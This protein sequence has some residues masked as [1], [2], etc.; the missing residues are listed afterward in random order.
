MYDNNK[1]ELNL[2]RNKHSEETVQKILDASLKLFLEKGYEQTSILDIVENLGGLTRGAFYHHFKSKAEVLDALGDRMSNENNFFEKIKNDT[3]LNGLQKIQKIIKESNESTERKTF[4]SIVLQV[5][6]LDHPTF[7]SALI[8]DNIYE[9]SPLFQ[10][11]IEEGIADG[12]IPNV[13]AKLLSELILLL[14]N[15]WMVPTL[16]QSTQEEFM[17]KIRLV[18]RILEGMGVPIFSD[19]IIKSVDQMADDLD[20]ELKE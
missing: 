20:W 19:E 3:N 8:R 11:L 15:I 9:V 7:L 10:E 13:N 12:S 6:L 5:P 4:N 14:T 17:E 2:P 18:S 16:Y 1:E